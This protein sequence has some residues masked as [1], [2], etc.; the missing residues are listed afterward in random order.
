MNIFNARAHGAHFSGQSPFILDFLQVLVV[1]NF[2]D[3]TFMGL[4]F[5]GKNEFEV[6]IKFSLKICIF[7]IEMKNQLE[8]EMHAILL[9]FSSFHKNKIP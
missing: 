5:D 1:K 8:A 2:R 6:E 7:C 4:N 3:P 9:K